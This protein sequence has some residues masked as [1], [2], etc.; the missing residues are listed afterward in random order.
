MEQSRW[1][2]WV[3][4]SSIIAQVLGIL[5]LTGVIDTGIAEQ[6]EQ[7]GVLALQMF[8]ALGIINNPT[9]KVNW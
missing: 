8:A 3:L 4:W 7:I 9:D 5:V 6:I 2:S 1:K